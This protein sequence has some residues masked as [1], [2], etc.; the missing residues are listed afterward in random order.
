MTYN[1][2]LL[3]LHSK[4]L[5]AASNTI[6]ITDR[7][8]TMIWVN[9]AAVENY[10]YSKDELIGNNP[11]MLQSGKHST[12][13]YDDLWKT[14]LDGQVWAG[15][16]L[17]CTKNG[18]II[19]EEMNITPV[20]ENG[21]ASHFIAIKQNITEHKK[22][23]EKLHLREFMIEHIS[24]AIFIATSNGKILY[25]ND[26]A[27]S[28]LKLSRKDLFSLSVKDFDQSERIK[29]W[30]SFFEKIVDKGDLV[31]ETRYRSNKEK[32]PVEARV[33]HLS[34]DG[35]EYLCFIARDFSA[36]RQA[37]EALRLTVEGTAAKTGEEFF[38]SCVYHLAQALNVKASL[39]NRVI[40][41]N[42]LKVEPLA[43][44]MEKDFHQLESYPLT[45]T[46]CRE[47]IINAKQKT[48][49]KLKLN[50][51]EDTHP[52]SR[53]K[54]LSYHGI[55]LLNSKK[56]V[57]GQLAILDE[58]PIKLSKREKQL[59]KIFATRAGA[60]I[61]RQNFEED[62]RRE[63]AKAIAANEATG[64]FLA[65]MSHE[66]RTP[67]NGVLG[68]TQILERDTSL[69]QNQ[70]NALQIIKESGEHLLA[71][72][73]DAL[74]LAKVEAEKL[75]IAPKPLG[76]ENFLSAIETV[77]LQEA[78]TKNLRLTKEVHELTHPFVLADERRLKQVLFN[79]VS[80]A[81]KFTEAG[82]ITLKLYQENNKTIINVIDTGAGIPEGDIELIFSP[83]HQAKDRMNHY[84][85]GLGLTISKRLAELMDGKL[86]VQ[87]TLGKGSSFKLSLNLPPSQSPQDEKIKN[88]IVSG[89]KGQMRS[90]HIFAPENDE[91]LSQTLSSIGFNTNRNQ[92]IEK[93]I[94]DAKK[95]DLI[96]CI[97][98]PTNRNNLDDIRF[99][100][101]K[102]PSTPILALT[103]STY[104]S[105]E[106][107]C[108]RAG[109]SAF[110]IKPIEQEKL[111]STLADLL[112][113]EWEYQEN[114]ENENLLFPTQNT[115]DKL[116]NL[117]KQGDIVAIR[118]EALKLAK[119]SNY[120]AFTDKLLDYTTQF[121][122]KAIRNL[123]SKNRNK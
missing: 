121:R 34:Y 51:I 14:I 105:Y 16:I 117:C 111:Y 112:D 22:I 26:A 40:D 73:N 109:A 90:I 83:F 66:L 108:L 122:I 20:I 76:L 57:I 12:R 54:G 3:L 53:F 21:K 78:Q 97:L 32:R 44:W 81:I 120:Q 10:G 86:E 69:N 8:G 89:Y 102:A 99:L 104:R 98:D 45:D 37:E 24:D 75:D 38:K 52:L 118:D 13:F 107:Q 71:L 80:N 50:L 61:I 119:E 35:T 36:R 91:I 123:V 82:T 1:D 63:K 27:L 60:E 79:L 18:D 30:D 59:L 94:E 114:N 25:A 2:S 58:S 29:D 48:I 55:P 56:E 72:I 31:Y 64:K 17:N 19:E 85:S 113:I 96:V 49:K 33:N 65:N 47:V 106:F 95:S 87:S 6:I 100:R 101:K 43:L 110:L 62:L 28:L 116:F 92:T 11:R 42:R 67:L 5:D 77:F 9:Q 46:P 23:V 88:A 4:A 103:T 15:T 70:K 7:A 84:G 39:V 93:N 41:G 74:D 68:Y 115:L